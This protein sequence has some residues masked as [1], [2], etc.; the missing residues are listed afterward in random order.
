MDL[1][2]QFE[3]FKKL[4][5]ELVQKYT[6]DDIYFFLR[7]SEHILP[8]G[9]IWYAQLKQKN[10]KAANLYLQLLKAYTV[11]ALYDVTSK[12]IL[13]GKIN[14][15][16]LTQHLKEKSWLGQKFEI[17]GF[18]WIEL[19]SPALGQFLADLKMEIESNGEN[20]VRYYLAIDSL[21]IKFEGLLR[22]VSRISGA[23]VHEK[24]LFQSERL[25][26][27]VE[28]LENKAL[29]TTYS[30]EDVAFLK[31]LFTEHGLDLSNNLG[32][33]YFQNSNYTLG[34]MLLLFFALL[35][36]GN[37]RFTQAE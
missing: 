37:L 27:I 36:V 28:L 16:S 33:C 22:E 30:K 35:K 11:R 26:S 21:G 29:E 8:V 7:N 25:F 5:D 18:D 34:T 12:G 14:L 17:S 15:E 3:N 13:A 2:L 20:P 32:R 1:N 10:F 24:K 4:T 6:S 31:A 19:L 23:A 9:D